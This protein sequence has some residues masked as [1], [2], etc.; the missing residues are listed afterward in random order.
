M[1]SLVK[2]FGR[3]ISFAEDRLV[4]VQTAVLNISYLSCIPSILLKIKATGKKES[5]LGFETNAQ[6]NCREGHH[7]STALNTLYSS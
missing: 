6:L 3:I 4:T 2:V 7:S 5:V 1:T